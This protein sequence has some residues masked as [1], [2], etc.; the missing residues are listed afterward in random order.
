MKVHNLGHGINET[1]ESLRRK[2]VKFKNM[3][4]RVAKFI[5]CCKVCRVYNKH[6]IYSKLLMSEDA[7]YPMDHLVMDPSGKLPLTQ[8]GNRYLL[9][10]VDVA[11]ICV[12]LR[13]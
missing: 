2:G 3:E 10:I 13:D 6:Q 11:T 9:V 7:E 8:R 4:G 5:S 12:V 1:V